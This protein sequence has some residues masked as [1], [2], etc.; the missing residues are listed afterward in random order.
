M[1][2]FERDLKVIFDKESKEFMEGER[3]TSDIF[4]ADLFPVYHP[5]EEL[6]K[7]YD[8]PEKFEVW[9]I[10]VTYEIL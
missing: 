7:N 4:D 10:R 3:G 8:E 5:D 6:I 9:K 2:K 1:I